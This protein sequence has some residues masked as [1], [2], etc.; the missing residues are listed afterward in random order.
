MDLL[1]ALLVFAADNAD[2]GGRGGNPS[3]GT[4]IATVLI[5][6][7][8]VLIGGLALAYVFSR[9]RSRRRALERH[10]APPR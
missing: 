3:E 1:N 4:G 6:A 9:G 7:A 10:P 8:I 5:I 2:V